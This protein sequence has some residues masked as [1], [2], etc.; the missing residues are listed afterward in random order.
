MI[1]NASHSPSHGL[2]NF[3]KVTDKIH[4]SKNPI[5]NASLSLSVAKPIVFPIKNDLRQDHS[6]KKP[7]AE[8]AEAQMTLSYEGSV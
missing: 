4:Y 6:W 7:A 8:V 3:S 1:R 2:T 5:K